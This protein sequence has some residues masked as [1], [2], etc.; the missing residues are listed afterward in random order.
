MHTA[1]P[2]RTTR[3]KKIALIAGGALALLLAVALAVSWVGIARANAPRPI[4]ITAE[5]ITNR[6]LPLPSPAPGITVYGTHMVKEVTLVVHF[7]TNGLVLGAYFA[8]VD[9]RVE[10][11][12]RPDL[13][14]DTP[15]A[16][17]NVASSMTTQYPLETDALRVKVCYLPTPAGWPFRIGDYRA[18]FEPGSKATERMQ[19]IVGAISHQLYD[20]LWPPFP[21]VAPTNGWKTAILEVALPANSPSATAP[22]S[23]N[24]PMNAASAP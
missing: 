9:T 1:P 6:F 5:G 10:G 23:T 8:R 13:D 11:V 4:Q 20:R 22:L 14:L 7:P 12:W 2:A 16:Y 15:P 19:R 3:L 18:R 17:L 24:Q 21:L